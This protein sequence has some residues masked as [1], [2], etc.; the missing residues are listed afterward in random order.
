M[1]YCASKELLCSDWRF[2]SAPDFL[3]QLLKN[4]WI[5][6]E[7]I[8]VEIVPKEIYDLAS[9]RTLRGKKSA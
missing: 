5:I 1:N 7:K 2:Y 6:V 3:L 9:H 4:S 8:T